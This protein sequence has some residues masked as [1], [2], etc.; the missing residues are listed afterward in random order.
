MKVS[1]RTNKLNI[2]LSIYTNNIKI[3]KVSSYKTY[4]SFKN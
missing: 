1:T 4:I 3:E 2:N